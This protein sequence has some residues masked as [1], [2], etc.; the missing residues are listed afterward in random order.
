M[1]WIGGKEN[2]SKAIL[3]NIAFPFNKH[4]GLF[5][6]GVLLYCGVILLMRI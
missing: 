2:L 4:N 3:S 5:I 6:G 1:K